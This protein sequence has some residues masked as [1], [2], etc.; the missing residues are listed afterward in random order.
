[1]IGYE[2]KNASEFGEWPVCPI[3]HS[4]KWIHFLLMMQ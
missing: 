1:M 3:H 4:Q 2:K